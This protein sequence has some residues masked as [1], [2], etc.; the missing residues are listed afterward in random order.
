[1]R[2]P[3]R[4]MFTAALMLAMVT[5]LLAGCLQFPQPSVAPEPTAA[6]TTAVAT[7]I[8]SPSPQPSTIA[9]ATPAAA[10]G[11]RWG[12]WQ[13]A[14]D[15]QMPA[16][17]PL[18]TLFSPPQFVGPSLSPD[19]N[20]LLVRAIAPDH[21]YDMGMVV[22]LAT[23]EQKQLP[24][25][26]GVAGI[27]VWNW[28]GDGK[29]VLLSIDRMGDE[30]F[31][32]FSIDVSTGEAVQIL[33]E[34]GV[35]VDVQEV[36]LKNP[37]QVL[38]TTNRR[39]KETFDLY[40]ANIESGELT[41]VME[42]PGTIS[43]YMTD[44]FGTL[45]AVRTLREDGGE[46][47]LLAKNPSS[48]DK[49]F[50]ADQWTTALRIDYEDASS[51]GF[52]GFSASG[53]KMYYADTGATD[54]ATLM[55]MDIKTLQARQIAHDPDFNIVS[56]WH[57][58]K[59]DAATAVRVA[60]EHM[61]WKALDLSMQP[62][63]D[64]LAKLA[65]GD[66]TFASTSADDSQW[67]IAYHSDTGS[68]AYALYEPASGRGRLLF[69]ENP[70][71]DQQPFVPM[72]T[73]SFTASDGMKLR[74]YATFPAGLARRNLPMVLLVHGGP[75]ARDEWGFNPEV[76][77]LANRG[78]LV[79]QVNF[80]GSTGFGKAFLN[81]GDKQ[82]G[83]D[84]Q[85][86]LTDA[87]KYA[88]DQGWADPQRVAIM[89]ASYGGYAALAGAAFTPDVY[90]CAVDMFGPSSLLT[91][92]DSIPDYWKPMLSQMYRSIGHPVDEKDMLMERSPLYHVDNIKIPLLIAQGG[93]D[94]RVKPQESEQIVKA[95]QERNLPVEYLY[96]PDSGHG[97]N[98]T[99][100]MMRFY[101]SCERFLSEHIGGRM[102]R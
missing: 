62:H 33:Y 80:R 78:Y 79:L 7:R 24:Y 74:G 91:L 67:L 84:M 23:G 53:D 36:D 98:S 32:L 85:Q 97:I 71:L 52:F 93:N 57:D 5:A 47:I 19:G 8:V 39:N 46:D 54:T 26:E 48:L 28:A 2:T 56:V 18:T 11:N 35:R 76:Q 20:F 63:I 14:A 22:D 21:S 96:F 86:D 92:L 82:W 55:E 102:S 43:Q 41:P 13:A 66:F 101:T 12:A 27:P 95:L 99:E 100:D 3:L 9:T 29:H 69:T 1:M 42:N 94:V 6:A 75:Q 40:R 17:I 83:A 77:F 25:P 30:N 50:V 70:L 90:A 51:T 45:L 31:G 59:R 44:R 4:R 72:E 38:L 68:T 60:G 58:L 89:G 81:A 37:G 61:V 88:V 10:A 65:P 87:V 16:L 49:K 73:F 15:A 64:A 34:P